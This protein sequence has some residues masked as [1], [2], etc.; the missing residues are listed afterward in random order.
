MLPEGACNDR[1]RA[2]LDSVAPPGV[3]LGISLSGGPDS[4]ALL[5]LA[6]AARPGMVE[7][8][9]VDH[10][11]RPG[12]RG[13]AE[14]AAVI[15]EELGVMHTIL[16]AEW[17]E[18]P[19]TA[20]QERARSERYR[21]LAAWAKQRGL[22]AVLTGHHA[23]DQAETLLMRLN[24]GAGVRGL[25]AMR[26]RSIVPG[27][28]VPLLRPLLGWRRGELE[29]ICIDAGI[30]AIADPSNAD[31][32]FERVRVR[33][34]LARSDDIDPAALAAAAGHLASADDALDWAVE[35]EWRC[36][37]EKRECALAYRP[38]DAPPEIL[39]R[40]V[41]RAIA[42][43]ASEASREPLRARELDPLIATLA[44]GGQAT[45]R[46]VVCA[47]G[48]EW[49]FSPAPPRRQVPS[50]RDGNPV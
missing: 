39:R 20:V 5:L 36:A 30:Q 17:P 16:T 15:C 3:R 23:D 32:R 19:A 14:C 50:R 49:R 13:E 37:I 27:S 34:A 33:Q 40:L 21:L 43:M 1:F 7:A 47:G 31:G 26:A 12:S 8:A 25:A 42:A 24:R 38:S 44:R 22:D 4:L 9:T 18:P 45:L 28:D 41:T 46:G 10:A 2:D 48:P 11:L 29:R 35:Q 6:A